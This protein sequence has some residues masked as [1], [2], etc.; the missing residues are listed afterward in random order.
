M[1]LRNMQYLATGAGYW[2]TFHESTGAQRLFH[3][4]MMPLRHELQDQVI[5][6]STPPAKLVSSNL[7]VS[8]MASSESEWPGS[9]PMRSQF[10]AT[11]K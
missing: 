5:E 9:S 3:H 6:E 2:I 1:Y 11:A 7:S 10:E 8:P 4:A